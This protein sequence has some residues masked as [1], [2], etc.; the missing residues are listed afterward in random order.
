MIG[1][2]VVPGG[3]RFA[4]WAPRAG[5]V[6]VRVVAPAATEVPLTRAPDGVFAGTVAGLAAGADYVYVVDGRALPD[7]ASRHQP[8]G[9]QGPSRVVDPA[10]FAWTDAGWRGLRMP[11]VVLY[12]LHVGTFGEAGTFDGVVAHLDALR[13]LGVTAIELMPIGAFPGERNWGYDGVHWFAPQ[14]SYGGPEGLCRLVDAA[15]ARGLGVVLDVVYNHVGPE[16]NVLPAFGPYFTD[17]YATPWGDAVNFDGADGAGV[18]RHVLENVR[19]WIRDFHLDGLR[20]DAVHAIV[21]ASPRHILE[22][23]A[24]AAH[25]EGA[26]QGR[27]VVV[28]AESDL[29]DPRL[30]ATIEADGY[31]LDAQWSDDFHHAVHALLTGERN[32]YYADFGAAAD[33]A[34]ALRDRFVYDGRHSAFR[35]RVHGAPATH[36][37]ADRF[38]V[39]I[40]NHDQIGNRARGERLATLLPPAARR[41]ATALLLLSPY[42]PLLFMGEEW[43]AQEPFL[44]FTSHADP[45]LARAVCEGRRREFADFAW[46]G[47]VPDPQDPAT[48]AASRLDRRRAASSEGAAALALHRDLLALRRAEPAL[49]PGADVAVE[50]ACADACV[51]LTLRPRAGRAL[52]VACNCGPDPAPVDAGAAATWWSSDVAR[53]GGAGRAI[54]ADAGRVVV[55]GHVAVVL[56]G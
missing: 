30:V 36:V 20:L 12:E 1:A 50:V 45:A 9:V 31:G 3:V 53:Y 51:V 25:V 24:A 13:D 22:E 43:G 4:V 33:L 38:V 14:A 37:P 47:T 5:A 32:G 29:N 34:K 54:V 26:A 19:S 48:F 55:P 27:A 10:R 44:Y 56:A 16:G 23:I 6:S 17:R 28:I 40:Q 46:A 11:D 52:V 21:D 39:A 8:A 2:Q 41:V 18:R 42:V 15:H 35:R 7:P 49:R